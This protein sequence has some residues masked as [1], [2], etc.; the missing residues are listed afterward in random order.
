M[1]ADRGHPARFG[2]LLRGYRTGAA[3]TQEELARRSGLS[4]RAVSDMERGHTARPFARWIELLA[5]ALGLPESGRARL[6][7]AAYGTDDAAVTDQP[8]NRGGRY[9]QLVVPRQLPADLTHFVGRASE[10]AALENLVQRAAAGRAGEAVVISAIGGTAGVGKTALAVHLGHKAAGAFPDGQLYVNLGGFGPS[11]TPLRPEVA[12]RAFV[13]A[14]GAQFR[15]V[16]ADLDAQ[17]GLYR[18]LLA[19]K[20]I[21]V[22]LDNAVDEQQA[23]PLLPGSPGCLAVV[24]SRRELIGLAAADGAG[25]LALDVLAD[26]EARELLAARLGA[27][28]VA[29]EPAAVAELTG[30]CARLPLALAISAALA[31]ARPGM[32]LADLTAELRDAGTRLDALDAG[33]PSCSMRT[34]FSWSYRALSLPGARMFRLLGLHPGPGH[35]AA[36]GCQPGRALPA[37]HPRPAQ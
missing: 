31:A 4:V 5:D 23:R 3:L 13:Y 14:L 30:L 33:E 9:P 32:A 26:S 24:T 11:A 12:I 6:I 29:A 19:D 25:L 7:G 28:R 22:V 36:H 35:L 18:S 10:L 8:A 2:R 1:D 27:G 20:R 37:P 21:L 16:P 17:V 15:Q 34:V